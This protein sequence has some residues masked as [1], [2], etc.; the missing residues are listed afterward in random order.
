MRN[1]RQ[2]GVATYEMTTS[3]LSALHP[4]LSIG[5]RLRVT[6]LQTGKQ[7]IVTVTGRI[8]ASG[9]RIVDISRGAATAIGLTGNS[10]SVNIEVLGRG[11]QPDIA[12][13]QIVQA[14][15]VT[16]KEEPVVVVVKETPKEEPV[17]VVVEEPPKEEPVVVAEPKKEKP[18]KEEPPK[19][20]APKP[21]PEPEPEPKP[22]IAAAPQ[23]PGGN[24][25]IYNTIMSPGSFVSDSNTVLPLSQGMYGIPAV[26][27]VPAPAPVVLPAPILPAPIL[28][29]P[30]LSPPPPP[31]APEPP[32]APP[33]VSMP[34]R[35]EIVVI[36]IHTPQLQAPA[37]APIPM[38]PPAPPA[39]VE[40]PRPEIVV[41]PI[42]TLQ[43]QAP[44]PAP[45]PPPVYVPAPAPAPIPPPVYVPAPAPTPPP[46]YI[47]APAPND[48][49][50]AIRPYRP[51]PNSGGIYRVQVGAYS[52]MHN[53]TE[54]FNFLLASG[55]SPAYETYGSYYRVVIPRVYPSEMDNLSRRLGAQGFRE[56]WVRKEGS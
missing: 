45:I 18:P 50:A 52:S 16:V 2:T 1:F 48:S 7:V 17:V 31:P 14:D 41:I 36:P 27:P 44:A 42:H 34:F 6:S 51:D 20:K 5:T 30:V 22:V 39:V 3:E 56:I 38:P 26:E 33:V 13:V 54:V 37:P 25:T 8:P 28:P 32:P 10:G 53:A 29:P 23:N 55:F 19:K 12:P 24:I 9:S 4:S 21:E 15:T 46:V 49:V 47:P 35:P 43:P 11:S 40:Q